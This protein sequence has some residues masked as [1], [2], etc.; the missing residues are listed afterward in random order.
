MKPIKGK[1][2]RASYSSSE[3]TQEFIKEVFQKR[4]PDEIEARLKVKVRG[5]DLDENS[6]LIESL[7]KEHKKKITRVF[8]DITGVSL[9]PISDERVQEFVKELVESA[10]GHE[11]RG[12]FL[13]RLT[14]P[15]KTIG[16]YI[17]VIN[18]DQKT[19][20][21]TNDYRDAGNGLSKDSWL[22]TTG[23][24]WLGTSLPSGH[25][26]AI[27]GGY[28]INRK[29]SEKVYPWE[30]KDIRIHIKAVR[31]GAFNREVLLE[32]FGPE[33]EDSIDTMDVA[34]SKPFESTFD[35]EELVWD[36]PQSSLE[37]F[38]QMLLTLH[39]SV[40]VSQAKRY[41]DFLELWEELQFDEILRVGF[42][43]G[44]SHNYVDD[45]RGKA[46]L[47]RL[48]GKIG[49]NDLNETDQILK[50]VLEAET[51]PI[52]ARLE[53]ISRTPDKAL[54]EG[55]DEILKNSRVGFMPTHYW[56]AG[57]DRLDVYLNVSS[58]SPHPLGINVIGESF[59]MSDSTIP[60]ARGGGPMNRF[61][62]KPGMIRPAYQDEIIAAFVMYLNSG[63]D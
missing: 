50:E 54:E 29:K 5:L 57:E 48:P 6:D 24:S 19:S 36:F 30:I 55:W 63:K 62:A 61:F 42:F 25:G 16:G 23:P 15:K 35:P 37:S 51:L 21:V 34:I 58:A 8:R 33:V 13:S 31:D 12:G 20:E 3:D 22:G 2:G 10:I 56:R 1:S 26:K 7:S 4:S 18:E 39:E 14:G 40:A 41:A 38:I 46:G 52:Y 47:G 17:E 45:R 11:N 27:G 9:P 59:L 60:K 32:A 28:S 44:V 49:H 43:A 53:G